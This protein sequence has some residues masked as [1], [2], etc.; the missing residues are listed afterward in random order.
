[1]G[2]QEETNR[3]IDFL[4]SNEIG[5]AAKNFELLENL[6]LNTKTITNQKNLF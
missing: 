4:K 6:D 5:R 2:S 3:V 1:M